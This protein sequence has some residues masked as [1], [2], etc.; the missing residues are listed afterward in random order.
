MNKMMKFRIYVNG[1]HFAS[2]GTPSEVIYKTSELYK[3]YGKENV[4]VFEKWD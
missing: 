4:S 1:Q 3:I 2:C